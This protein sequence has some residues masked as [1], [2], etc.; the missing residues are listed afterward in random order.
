[1]LFHKLKFS[2]LLS[3]GPAGIDLPMEPL[4]VLIGPNGSGKSNLLEAISLFQAAPRG[5]S[6]PISRMGG[7]REW[8]WKGPEAPRS[9][10]MEVMCPYRNSNELRH[11]LTLADQSGRV[12]VTDEQIE[13]PKTERI[14]LPEMID[15]DERHVRLYC[16]PPQDEHAALDLEK[17]NARR[18]SESEPLAIAGL[19]SGIIYF[20]ENFHPEESLLSHATSPTY[21]ALW[22]LKEQYSRIR[23]YRNWSFGPDAKPRQ[24]CSAHERS[25]FLDEGGGN[26][27]LVISQLHGTH[28]KSFLTALSKLFDGIV[29]IQCPV[30]GGTVALFLEEAGNRSIPA[31]RLSDGTLRYLCLLAVLL[32]P[33]PPPLICIEEPEL[34]LHPDL[35]PTLSGLMQE[36]SERTQLIVT[37]H[38]DILVD[39]LTDRPES[40]VV[41]EKHDGQTEM[42][43]LDKDD[44]AKWLKD[45]RLGDLWT[46]GEL[47]GNRW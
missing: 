40:V 36:A 34:G 17:E 11:A 1:M 18:L 15:S 20:R 3:F 44:L 24:P 38:S 33:E 16:R 45:Y 14:I 5:I 46:S 30:T 32:H 8:L 39:T 47:G 31:T 13:L 19:D 21:P 42:Q 2:G 25:D 12:I 43:R 7:V 26:L 4:T 37:T 41:C 23:L 27:P 10:R 6:E 29:D 22:H 35:L 28:K 9:I